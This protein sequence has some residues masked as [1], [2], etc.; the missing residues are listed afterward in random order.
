MM[1]EEDKSAESTKNTE[2]SENSDNG[3][4]IEESE[5]IK[6]INCKNVEKSVEKEKE[7]DKEE[8][9]RDEDFKNKYYY[10]AAEMDNL[11][12]RHSKEKDHLLKYGH[13]KIL[14]SLLDI[15]DNLD[16]TLHVL[17]EDAKDSQDAMKSITTGIEMVKTKFEKILVDN[18]LERIK[19]LEQD[20]DP[21][22]HEAM[23]KQEKENKKENEI[24]A[25]YQ[26]GYLLNGRLLRAAKVVIAK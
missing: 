24:I 7:E 8:G 20:F 25:E 1:K 10:L 17:V 22:I 6:D 11:I 14:F 18:G 9:E 21:R 15:M 19:T 5:N 13:E 4:Q 3:E 12:K 16:R 2:D 26:K 23:S